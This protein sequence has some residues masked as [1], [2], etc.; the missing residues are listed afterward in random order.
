[1]APRTSE[2]GIKKNQWW[3]AGRA[4]SG[5]DMGNLG[6]EGDGYSRRL[7]AGW[8]KCQQQR[9]RSRLRL[10]TPPSHSGVG[11]GRTVSCLCGVAGGTWDLLPSTSQAPIRRSTKMKTLTAPMQT[12]HG[13]TT[14][15]LFG[16]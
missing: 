16:R 1:M 15:R 2:A 12:Y 3:P 8:E 4:E 7:S 5:A 9:L 14:G 11:V 10:A 6:G 13:H